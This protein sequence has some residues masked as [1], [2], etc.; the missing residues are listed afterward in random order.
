MALPPL[1]K[2]EM[3]LCHCGYLEEVIQAYKVQS[4]FVHIKVRPKN[5]D[6]KELMDQTDEDIRAFFSSQLEEN[7]M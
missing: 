6:C 3:E 2:Q 5:L 4:Q 7:R 1:S